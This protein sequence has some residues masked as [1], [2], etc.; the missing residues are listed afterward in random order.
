MP[1]SRRFRL[2]TFDLDDTLWEV[3]PVLLRA[4]QRVGRW[5]AA[6]CPEVLER[7]DTEALIALRRGL[8]ESEPELRHRISAL[9]R[10]AMRRALLECGYAPA[11][12]EQLA[13]EAFEV[14]LAAR[15][16]VEPFVS[17]EPCL[18]ELSRDYLLGVITNGNA[19][20]FRMPLGR[21]FRFA[22]RAETLG[23]GK[24]D[25]A[26]FR[27]AAEAAGVEPA[28]A[29]HVGDHPEH[30]VEG[31]HAAGFTAVWFN[32][33]GRPWPAGEPPCTELRDLAQLPAVLRR[34]EAADTGPAP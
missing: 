29:V 32:P 22:V 27:A 21:Y 30:D 5:L 26:H 15:H 23:I 31:A 6:R 25:P 19:D 14:F 20:I 16:E 2:V 8:L 4:E 18:A 11:Q 24:P 13:A 33:A 34:L 12:A 1:T 17:V 9:R 7:Y 10:E 3:G 28:A